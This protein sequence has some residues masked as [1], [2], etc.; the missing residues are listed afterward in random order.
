MDKSSESSFG[1]SN[2]L[3]PRRSEFKLSMFKRATSERLRTTPDSDLDKQEQIAWICP[4]FD[5]ITFPDK[6]LFLFEREKQGHYINQRSSQ[7]PI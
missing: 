6:F 3:V 4:F 7:S 5:G 2:S 1:A